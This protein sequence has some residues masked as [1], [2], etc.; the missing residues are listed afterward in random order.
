MC[1][2]VAWGPSLLL[3]CPVLISCH[4]NFVCKVAG[5]LLC[6]N[7]DALR[8]PRAN[9]VGAIPS[10]FCLGFCDIGSELI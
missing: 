4:S 2:R 3:F 5:T 1:C 10:L 7:R 6:A 8:T 9:A